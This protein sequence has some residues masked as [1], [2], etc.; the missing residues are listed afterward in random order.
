M[1]ETEWFEGRGADEPPPRNEGLFQLLLLALLIL[2]PMALDGCASPCQRSDE[3]VTVLAV[4]ETHVIQL[5]GHVE[6][7]PR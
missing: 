2:S 1:A 7:C 6:F 3:I 4:N 5:R